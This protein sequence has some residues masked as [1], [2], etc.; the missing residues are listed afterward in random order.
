MAVGRNGSGP[1]RFT[2]RLAT[3]GRRL[4]PQ[5]QRVYAVLLGQRDHPTAEEVFLRAKQRMPEISLATVYNSLDALVECGLVKQVN[6]DRAATRYCPNM[7]EHGHFYCE[8]CGGVFD[9]HWPAGR[10]VGP[11][12]VPRGFKPAQVEISIRGLCAA[13][14]RAPA[15]SP[16]EAHP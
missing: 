12:A 11:V 13:C 10:G 1:S 9:V 3:L 16:S 6:L 5:R 15:P 7:Q 8:R 4:T 14:T 2:E